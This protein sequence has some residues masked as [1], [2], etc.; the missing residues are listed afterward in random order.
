M[1]SAAGRR[2]TRWS[3]PRRSAPSQ[4]AP[5]LM[6]NT[7]KVVEP[8]SLVISGDPEPG[9][10]AGLAEGDQ[11]GRHAPGRAEAA[12]RPGRSVDEVADV[13]GGIVGSWPSC[14]WPFCCWS[15]WPWYWRTPAGGVPRCGRHRADW[16][17]AVG[18]GDGAA[19]VQQGR[20]LGILLASACPGRRPLV[21][22]RLR[23]GGAGQL[24]DHHI[25]PGTSR[26]RTAAAGA[27]GPS[28][29]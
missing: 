7:L 18:V 5:A 9:S 10:S 22:S 4:F 25:G 13:F 2:R 23:A 8:S 21:F 26:A 11:L 6:P 14:D 17:R 3:T 20:H 24:A 28:S 29:T 1:P 12:G 16:R 15:A 27:A 19:A